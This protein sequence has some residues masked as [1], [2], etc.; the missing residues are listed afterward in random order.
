MNC[1]INFNE[2]IRADIETDEQ[3]REIDNSLP[4]FQRGILTSVEE[5]T[6]IIM[7]RQNKTSA[8]DDDMPITVLKKLSFENLLKITIIFNHLLAST[9]FP[10]AWKH[11]IC[12]PIPKPGKF[13]LKDF[14]NYLEKKNTKSLRRQQFVFRRSIWF[15]YESFN[16]ARASKIT[17]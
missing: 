14:Q 5:V 15:S 16:I 2:E 8:G 12:C 10:T 9:F 7:T 4:D 11:A 3:S 1:K 17:Q 6:E 13:H